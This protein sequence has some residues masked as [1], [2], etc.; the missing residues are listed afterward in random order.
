MADA[1]AYS[2]IHSNDYQERAVG[3]DAAPTRSYA[4]RRGPREVTSQVSP[5]P[6]AIVTAALGAL[7]VAAWGGIAPYVGPIFG[8][9]AD[10]TSAW[11]WNLSHS[12]L[13][14]V[15]AIA[16]VLAA[17]WVVA[18]P[19]SFVAGRS[20]T[21]LRVAGFVSLLAGAWFIF[22]PATWPVLEGSGYFVGGS[23][24]LMMREIGFSFGP[25]IL[26]A[27]FGG[28]AMGMARYRRVVSD[29]GSTWSGSPSVL[30]QQ[31]S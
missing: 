11:T 27:A 1:N 21:A 28:Y 15:P 26:L 12:L 13:A 20:R 14:L 6:V 16:A 4:S 9:S 8:Y 23:W 29:T 25:G 5:L 7:L 22:G 24:G 17:L 18:R 10:G 2:A 3:I 31:A 30:H 19:P